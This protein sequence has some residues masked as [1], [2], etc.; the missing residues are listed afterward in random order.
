MDFGDNIKFMEGSIKEMIKY[1]K[2]INE[3]QLGSYVSNYVKDKNYT[4]NWINNILYYTNQNKLLIYYKTYYILTI[5]NNVEI[6]FEKIVK[7]I[8]EKTILIIKNR[9][10]LI[11]IDSIF[12]I[13]DLNLDNISCL[14]LLKLKHN[15]KNTCLPNNI[16]FIDFVFCDNEVKF[17]I[18]NNHFIS[19]TKSKIYDFINNTLYDE[20]KKIE[21]TKKKIAFCS[22]NHNLF[23]NE[24]YIYDYVKYL[25]QK[26]YWVDY[27]TLH[28]YSQHHHKIQLGKNI[29]I[30]P[31]YD[32]IIYE[33]SAIS[34]FIK[35]I[36]DN[37]DSK[38]EYMKNKMII[39]YY[40][41]YTW[42]SPPS[43]KAFLNKI[44]GSY[45]KIIYHGKRNI[46]F[47]E[48][49]ISSFSYHRTIDGGLHRMTV[50]DKINKIG[51]NFNTLVLNP[52]LE[53]DSILKKEEFFKINNLN[54]NKKLVTIFL[55]WPSL[56]LYEERYEENVDINLFLME[57]KVFYEHFQ[58]ELSQFINIFE[59][60]SC[61]VIVKLH[62]FDS[63]YTNE[64][65]LYVYN[66]KKNINSKLCHQ[67]EADKNHLMDIF[68]DDIQW[69]IKTI[70]ER[71]KIIDNSFSCEILK[72]TNYGIVFSPTSIAWYNYLYDFPVMAISTISTSASR[73]ADWF[74]LFSVNE[75]NKHIQQRWD[76]YIKTNNIILN[77]DKL[78]NDMGDLYYGQKL[79]WEDIMK[80]PN[81]I[82][83]TFLNADHKKNFKYF[84]NHPFYGNAYC[85]NYKVISDQIVELID[86]NNNLI[87]TSEKINMYIKNEFMT[88]YGLEYINVTLKENIIIDIIKAPILNSNYGVSFLVGYYKNICN[89]ILEFNSKIEHS[90]EEDI[91]I[92]I[93]TGIKWITLGTKLSTEYSKYSV[94]EQFDLK[95]HSGWRIAST[96]STVGQKIFIKNL[97]FTN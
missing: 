17:F 43:F 6:E 65:V 74:T 31:Y 91:Y 69:G 49:Y 73:W 90:E 66:Y 79:Y 37:L 70:L 15:L 54:I 46:D 44:N 9:S 10:I 51:T 81:N 33:G 52:S 22:Q 1:R 94:N 7:D 5:D 40:T 38:I 83:K 20:Y 3:N 76:E 11:P 93:Y 2:I 88:I 53:N 16:L 28:N 67:Y 27:I 89:L 63:G 85:A 55:E 41:N 21:I 60:N 4:G 39:N 8:F 82:I 32:I 68:Y 35:M 14:H 19:C 13:L 56:Y 95:M 80:D 26:G 34:H 64:N 84:E 29:N 36:E 71:Y 96:S 97:L 61:N 72:Y 12:D 23:N 48:G 59:N 18:K 87:N 77:K 30:F 45:P 25:F 86:N 75:A 58:N 47:I 57:K 92:K 78:F 24:D 50:P 42:D 62:P